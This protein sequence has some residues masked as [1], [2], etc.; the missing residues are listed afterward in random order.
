ME[1]V[2]FRVPSD[3]LGRERRALPHVQHPYNPILIAAQ[4]EDTV[5]I[6]VRT[7]L[8]CVPG[9][10]GERLEALAVGIELS[11]PDLGRKERVVAVDHAVVRRK[12]DVADRLRYRCEELGCD[13]LVILLRQGKRTGGK[14]QGERSKHRF[15]QAHLISFQL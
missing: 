7:G 15:P 1:P 13:H 4:P 14:S 6:L 2:R 8:G 11:D 5:E 10:V 9:C 3:D 12:R